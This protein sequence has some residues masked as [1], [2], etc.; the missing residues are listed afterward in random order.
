MGI[1]RDVR[2]VSRG[3]AADE[4][5]TVGKVRL[6]DKTIHAAILVGRLLVGRTL[7]FG[8]SWRNKPQ[9]VVQVQSE[10]LW[11]RAL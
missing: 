2:G 6:V 7:A 11:L 1:G 5:N 8:F 10:E 4:E 9:G 3:R